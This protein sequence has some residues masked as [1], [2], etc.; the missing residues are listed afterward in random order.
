MPRIDLPSGPETPSLGLRT[1]DGWLSGID[2]ELADRVRIA[3]GE[4]LGNAVQHGPGGTFTL[5]WTRGDEGGAL[6]LFGGGHVDPKALSGAQLPDSNATRGRGLF[7][8]RT[9]ADAI[10]IDDDGA[11][12]LDF[13]P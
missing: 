7:I 3:A 2:E 5:E 10:T 12:R 1:L 9:V 6:R 13:E 8:L 4:L 11:V